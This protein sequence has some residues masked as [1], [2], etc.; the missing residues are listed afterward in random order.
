MDRALLAVL[1]EVAGPQAAPSRL[2]PAAG[3]S[4]QEGHEAGQVRRVVLHQVLLPS[5]GDREGVGDRG[6]AE[7]QS[8]GCAPSSSASA[9]C[10]YSA[11]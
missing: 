8:I 3:R 9:G 2:H 10:W 6:R 11:K 5:H 1:Q 4:S 7:A